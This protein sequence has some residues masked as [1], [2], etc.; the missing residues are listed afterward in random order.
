MLIES[1]QKKMAIQLSH[2]CLSPSV[3]QLFS[4]FIT[5]FFTTTKVFVNYVKL[6]IFSNE[7]NYWHFQKYSPF[8]K[9]AHVR[10]NQKNL[11][12]ERSS[13]VNLV[14]VLKKYCKQIVSADLGCAFKK[15]RRKNSLKAPVFRVCV[16]LLP[17]QEEEKEK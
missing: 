12:H 2:F 8:K 6:L 5:I 15:L 1:S 10:R 17:F 9:K 4:S 3:F 16:K 13:S 14:Y 7:M 11:A